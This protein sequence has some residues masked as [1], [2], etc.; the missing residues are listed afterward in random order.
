MSVVCYLN[1]QDSEAKVHIKQN[2]MNP[3]EHQYRYNSTRTLV[4][5][6]IKPS[7]SKSPIGALWPIKFPSHK[8]PSCVN[9]H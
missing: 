2:A 5:N 4:I 9:F 7:C 1:Y 6:N 8:L 3:T